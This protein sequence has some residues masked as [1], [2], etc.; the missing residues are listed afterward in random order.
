MSDFQDFLKHQ[1]ASVSMASFKPG[2]FA[3]VQKLYE[4]AVATYKDGFKGAYLLQQPG[5]D[6]GLSV[7][8]WD[9]LEEMEANQSEAHEKLLQQMAPFFQS[10]PEMKTFE[11]VCN[12]QPSD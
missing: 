3:E 12:I 2:K 11:L 7:I 6:E 8:F 10:P 9:S 4:Q 5:S 1:Y